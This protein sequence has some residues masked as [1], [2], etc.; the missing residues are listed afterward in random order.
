MPTR[1]RCRPRAAPP[2]L[3]DVVAAMGAAQVQRTPEFVEGLTRT[4]SSSDSSPRPRLHHPY[5]GARLGRAR[6]VGDL[7]QRRGLRVVVPGRG[8]H[9]NNVMGEQDL[10]PLGFHRHPAGRRMPSMMAP[11]VVLRDGRVGSRSAA[12]SNR[13]RSALLQTIVGV[14]DHGL[15]ARAA[16]QGPAP[17]PRMARSTLSLGSTSSA[18]RAQSSSFTISTCSLEASRRCYAATARRGAG[19]DGAGAWPCGLE[20]RAG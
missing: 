11:T 2:G 10:N 19:S 17:P 8:I 14:V 1:S 3:G 18:S 6:L 15:T 9:L 12:P 5:L 4:A 7:Q 13:I 20:A 16:V